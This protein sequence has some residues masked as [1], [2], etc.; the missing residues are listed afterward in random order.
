VGINYDPEPTGI[1]PYTSAIARHLATVAG[2]VAAFVGVPHYPSW[3]VPAQYR[4][5]FRRRESADPDLTVVRHTH[6]VPTKQTAISRAI[7]ELTFLLNVSLSPTARPDVVI[8][9]TPSLGGACA[10]AIIAARHNVPLITVVQD[11]MSKAASQSG[12]LGGGLVAG[13]TSTFE[14][15]SLRRASLVAL[16]SKSFAPH[17]E[18]YGVPAERL[19][20]LPNWTH[21]QRV[22]V[23]QN[24]ARRKL[25]WR[26]DA[27]I[28]LH[29][30]NMGLKQDLTNVIRAAGLLA[31]D[32]QVLILL[33]GDGSQRRRL[34]QE[35]AGLPNVHF[36]DPLSGEEYP[37]ALAAA[38]ILLVNER[39][40][41]RDMSL[42]SK[43]TSYLSAGRPIIA[44]VLPEGTTGLALERTNG[45]AVR[46]DPGSPEALSAAILEL[47]G[48]PARRALMGRAGRAFAK[49]NLGREGAMRRVE[50]LVQ[51][52]LLT[53]PRVPAAD[54]GSEL[55][56]TGRN[57]V[58]RDFDA[59]GYDRGRNKTWQAAWFA[60]QNLVFDT[61]WCP[62][63]LR[64]RI[65]R[66]FGAQIGER[67]FIRHRVRVLWPWKL[68]VKD[69][70]WI[71]EDAWLLNL[72][73]ITLERDVC[74]SQGA[75]L[76]T[77]SHDHRKPTFDYDN[78]PI[79]I[80][81]GAWIAAKSIVLRGAVIP[82]GAVVKAGSVV[83]RTTSW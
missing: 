61:W 70:C 16:V 53:G 23:D 82:P 45:A 42:P 25:G 10:G 47:R 59:A 2:S 20:P 39:P 36:L 79:T 30:G 77:G 57:R 6:Y 55:D 52:A 43:L 50:D 66:L 5:G 46:V 48:D 19:R 22:E 72:E 1:A 24:D 37:L 63:S 69:D 60:M 67:V 44:A 83:S 26:E 27:F 78:A 64:P 41:V 58:L 80:G 35:A 29:S 71:G 73:R 17:I 56:G 18:Q 32:P 81:E 15:R 62:A 28:V 74:V 13:M 14:G 12:I 65:L 54:P 11:L 49:E 75:F 34:E 8:A 38:D 40:T 51:E 3:R 33:L 31:A 4:G 7:Y 21:I 68:V 9:V 76:C